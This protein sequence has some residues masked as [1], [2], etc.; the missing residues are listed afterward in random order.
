MSNEPRILTVSRD[1][2]G[3]RLDRWLK[4]MAPD[5]PYVLV[6]KLIRKGQIRIDG[7]RAKMDTRIEQ[8]QEVRLSAA[9]PESRQHPDNKKVRKISSEDIAYI[10]SLV[11]YQDKDIIALNKPIGMATQGGS[12]VKRHIDGLLDGLADNDGVRPRLVHRLDKDTSGVLLLARSA[13]VAKALGDI[14]KG[15]DIKKIYWAIVTPTPEMMH[16]TIKAP[17]LKGGEQGREKVHVDHEEGKYAQTEYAVV[18]NAASRAAFVAFWP[19]TGRTHQIRVH[20]QIAGFPILGD[21]KY[22]GAS[23][24]MDEDMEHARTLHLH[25]QRL[26]FMHPTQKG[27]IMDIR[28]PLP[29]EIAKTWKTLGFNAKYKGDPFI[30]LQS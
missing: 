1:D 15:R 26:I 7:K 24:M 20:A 28:A 23:A 29:P 11:I 19:R 6:Q 21:G 18:E 9:K 3:Q 16:G 4:R 27:R 2:D 13:K 10:Q 8:G 22:G 14:F 30:D 17:L 25:A 5:L 12:K